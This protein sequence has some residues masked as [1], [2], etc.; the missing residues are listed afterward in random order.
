FDASSYSSILLL[1]HFTDPAPTQIYTLSLHDALPIYFVFNGTTAHGV[2]LAQRTVFVNQELRYQ[3][4]RNAFRASRCIRQLG[5]HQVDDVLR[6]VVLTPG[7][8][9]LSTCD[10]VRTIGIRF[11]FGADNAQ[12]STGVRLGQIHGTGPDAGVHVRQIFFFQFLRTVVVQR[13]TGTG[14]QHRRQAEGHIG[15]LHHFFNLTDQSFRHA[16]ATEIRVTTQT[17]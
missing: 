5:Q 14:G 3:E 15:A 12:V 13:Q 7:N 16:H 8:E 10:V 11:R 17:V 6:H 9:D 2:T 4:Q 1:S